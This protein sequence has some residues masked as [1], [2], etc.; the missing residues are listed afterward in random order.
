MKDL[1][2]DLNGPKGFEGIQ[3]V[4]VCECKCLHIKSLPIRFQAT[5][6]RVLGF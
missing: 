6:E 4:L 1:N 2:L 3:E 5:H